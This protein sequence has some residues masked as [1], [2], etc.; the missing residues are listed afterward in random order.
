MRPRTGS[1]DEPR[2]GKTRANQQKPGSKP[3]VESMAGYP[4][5]R[6]RIPSLGVSA[7]T[8]DLG[9]D[10][11]QVE[12]PG[13][14][15]DTGWFTESVP[16]GAVGASVISGHV[17][18]NGPAVFL[19]LNQ[20]GRGDRVEVDRSDGST[21]IFAVQRLKTFPKDRF[22]TELVYGRTDKPTL[23][24]ITCGGRYDDT[25]N[26]YDANVIAFATLVGSRS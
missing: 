4:P 10:E 1:S 14:A 13:N 2:Q 18:Y 19:D 24:L 9:I 22:P 7:R 25:A 21:A 3:G 12:V 5:T 15:S 11:G 16:P 26:D 23:R 20:L 8:L 6:V 17:T